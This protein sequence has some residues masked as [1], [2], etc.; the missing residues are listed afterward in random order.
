PVEGVPLVGVPVLVEP[1]PPPDPPLEIAGSVS[2]TDVV[3]SVTGVLK[4]ELLSASVNVVVEEVPACPAVGVKVR[5]C[6][7]DVTA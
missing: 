1:E 6:N 4:T 2:I 7:A 5:P 3:A